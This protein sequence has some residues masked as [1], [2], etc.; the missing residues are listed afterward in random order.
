MSRR[1]A[2]GTAGLVLGLLG[3]ALGFVPALGLI[4]WP[5][6]VGGLVLGLLGLVR[7]HRGQADNG[8]V[9]IAG[10]AL[11][12]LGLVV[13]VAWVVL[14]GR[15]SSDAENAL[16]DLQVQAEKGAV[17]VYEVT[18]DTRTATVSY[19]T[20]E[21]EVVRLPWTKEYTV[22]G[23]FGDGTLD[24]TTGADGGTVTCKL[25]VDGVERK[26]ATASGPHAVASCSG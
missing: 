17:L 5:L 1:N 20:V 6:V 14:F 11:S 2:P 21:Q 15:A 9:A 25:T 16:D 7:V 23:G 10:T 18:G 19:A 26:T 12:A 24:V 8:G 3:L 13:C 22:K 4:A